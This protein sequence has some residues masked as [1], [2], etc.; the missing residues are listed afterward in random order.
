MAN[1]CAA[2]QNTASL[3]AYLARMACIQAALA[4]PMS[5]GYRRRAILK[6]VTML[7]LR[8]RYDLD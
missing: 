1:A 3:R 5:P 8:L 4:A 2:G 7:G 6:V